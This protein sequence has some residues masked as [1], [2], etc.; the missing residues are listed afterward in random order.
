LGA[1]LFSRAEPG[2]FPE[3]LAVPTLFLTAP[4]FL[5]DFSLF[6]TPLNLSAAPGHK[7]SLYIA[8][9]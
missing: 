1:D 9:V 6:F 3:T 7:K 2:F 8:S 4:G 5:G